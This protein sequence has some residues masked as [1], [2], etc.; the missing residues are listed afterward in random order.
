MNARLDLPRFPLAALAL[1]LALPAS[2]QAL[3]TAGTSPGGLAEATPSADFVAFGEGAVA[4]LKTGLVWKR[5][6]EG[7]G[8]NGAG[9]DGAAALMNWS[10]ALQA[11]VAAS[12]DGAGDWRVPN[13]KEL[14]SIIEFCGHEPAINLDQFPGTPAE[15]FWTSTTFVAEPDR[16]WDVYFSDGYSGAS[17]KTLNRNAVRLVRA[18]PPGSLLAPQTISFGPAPAL[19]LG[20]SAVVSATASSGLPATLESR[21][22]ATCTLAGNT[23]TALAAGACTIAANQAGDAVFYPAPEALLDLVV[24]KH[25]QSIAFGETPTLTVGGSASVLVAASS[26]LP[27]TL[28]SAAPDTCSL[29]GSQVTGLAVGTC[30]ILADQAGD[31]AFLPAPTTSQSFAVTA[32]GDAGGGGGGDGS[33]PP[34]LIGYTMALG[35]G[36]HL[37]GNSLT[38][39]IDV[40]AQFGDRTVVESVWKWNAETQRWAFYTPQFNDRALAAYARARKLDLLAQIAPGE[41]Y[42]LKLKREHD[43]GAQEGEPVLPDV[44]ALA[45]G[46][47][48]LT[49]GRAISPADLHALLTAPSTDAAAPPGASAAPGFVS[50]WS[51]DNEQGKWLFYAPALEAQGPEAVRAYLE[52]KGYLDFAAGQK[53]LGEGRGF[54]IKK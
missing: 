5:C 10:S 19:L 31:D 7:Q 40:A 33:V 50:V 18:A 23:V 36:W 41:G 3:C 35:G 38:T 2:A 37:L 20:G 6:A 22:P 9:C 29:V 13:R 48:L 52:L 51:W 14:E 54:W 16:A 15:R 39:P 12:D 21:T 46:W 47:H 53:T 11:S 42:W 43:F 27:V 34:E 1:L 44:A 17:N 30:T 25:P 4:H 32:P 24:N 28:A 49:L 26:G 45:E 8:W